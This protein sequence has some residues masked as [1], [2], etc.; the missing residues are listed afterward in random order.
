LYKNG[1]LLANILA[2]DSHTYEDWGLIN[3]Q[4]YNYQISAINDNGE[5]ALSNPVTGIPSGIPDTSTD[6]TLLHND[7]QLTVSFNL[8]AITQD[9]VH[10]SDEGNTIINYKIYYSI[11]YFVNQT[12]VQLG[13]DENQYV[14][15]NLQNGVPVKLKYLL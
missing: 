10:P 5:S 4:Q 6:L 7:E 11:D 9:V 3:G 13:A 8:L 1:L 12:V 14:I 2:N 15:S